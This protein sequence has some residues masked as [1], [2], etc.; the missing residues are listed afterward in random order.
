MDKPLK[1]S[2]Y[3]DRDSSISKF[4]PNFAAKEGSASYA[5]EENRKF[6]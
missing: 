1:C 3:R 2:T 4:P 5:E 6:E